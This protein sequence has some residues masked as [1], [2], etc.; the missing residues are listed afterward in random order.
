MLQPFE[1]HR[2]DVR[3]MTRVLVSR[4]SLGRRPTLEYFAWHFT[5][6]RHHDIRRSIERLDDGCGSFHSHLTGKSLSRTL[7]LDGERVKPE[8]E[9]CGLQSEPAE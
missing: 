6:E 4:P 2:V 9:T 7:R 3:E 8:E 5:H 1:E